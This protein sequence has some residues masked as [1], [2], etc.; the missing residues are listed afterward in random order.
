MPPDRARTGH[1]R[2]GI[3]M[4]RTGEH[5]GECEVMEQKMDRLTVH[6]G[7]RVGGQ[8]ATGEVAAVWQESLHSRDVHAE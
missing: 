6:I 5:A 8:A 3:H 7:T 1:C 4:A 2:C